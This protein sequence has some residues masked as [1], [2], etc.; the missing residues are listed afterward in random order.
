MRF[1]SGIALV[2]LLGAQA[3]LFLRVHYLGD[4][5]IPPQA[6]P[7]FYFVAGGDYSFVLAFG[8]SP[9]I[10]QREL[11]DP[12]LRALTILLSAFSLLVLA[13]N[14]RGREVMLVFGALAAGLQFVV[15]A[16]MLGI[17]LAKT[18]AGGAPMHVELG[19]GL[20][21]HALALIGLIVALRAGANAT[22][23]DIVR[24]AG[25]R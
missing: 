3:F 8:A 7:R 20:A 16:A 25:H 13:L 15:Y 23:E 24:R 12:A 14:L 4:V 22:R 9:W 11:V 10:P 5:A 18:P 1:I 6:F 21:L 2:L 19:A 17:H